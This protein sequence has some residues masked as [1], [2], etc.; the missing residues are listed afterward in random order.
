MMTSTIH[1]SHHDFCAEQLR[2]MYLKLAKT[3]AIGKRKF[4]ETKSIFTLKE[5]VLI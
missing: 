5:L 1:R 2:N 4:L 3:D